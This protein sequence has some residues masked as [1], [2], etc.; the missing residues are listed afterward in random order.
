ME[1]FYFILIL[2]GVRH[3]NVTSLSFNAMIDGIVR[4][5]NNNYV[6]SCYYI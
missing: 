3:E 6:V 2:I 4:D 1:R 5:W